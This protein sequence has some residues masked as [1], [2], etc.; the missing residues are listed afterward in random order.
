MSTSRHINKI[1]IVGIIVTLILTVLFMCGQSLGITAASKA[2]KY[3]STLFDTSYVH[4]IDIVMDDWEGFIENCENEEYVYCTVVIDGKKYANTAIRA[5][6]NTSLS[7]VRSS[8][9]QRY[10]FKLEFDHY[11]DAKMMDGLDKLC[12]NNLI[13]DNTMMKDYVVYRIMSDFGVGSPLCSFAYLKVNGENW[14]LYLALEGVEDSF[15]QRNYGSEA[16]DLYKPDSLSFGGGRG[17][18]K[19]FNFDDLDFDFGFDFDFDNSGSGSFDPSSFT[20]GGSGQGGSDQG[21]SSSDGK[22]PGGQ[23][24]G[25]NGGGG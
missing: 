23:F 4:Q 11:E 5:K 21:G 9:S 24:P 2:M 8:G 18:G 10:S 16:G 6:G 19:G 15:L 7:S 25:G 12:L 22:T 3:E 1:C 20:P 13:Q 14:G 17:N